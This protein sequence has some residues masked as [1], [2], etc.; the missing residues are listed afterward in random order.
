MTQMRLVKCGGEAGYNY[1]GEIRGF[2][3]LTYSRS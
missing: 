2:W 3:V 1:E